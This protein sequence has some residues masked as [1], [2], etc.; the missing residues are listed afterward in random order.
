M[1]DLN[2]QQRF[3]VDTYYRL[4]EA[5]D[6]ATRSILERQETQPEKAR[7]QAHI[8]AA[9]MNDFVSTLPGTTP[10]YV[11]QIVDYVFECRKEALGPGPAMP[12]L[13]HPGSSELN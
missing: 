12:N 10:E 5:F 7:M 13:T 3:L 1:K 4:S 2:E 9:V 6:E 11:K 8:F